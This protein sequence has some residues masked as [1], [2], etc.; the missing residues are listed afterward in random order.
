MNTLNYEQDYSGEKFEALQGDK[1]AAKEMNE[2]EEWKI[3]SWFRK[4][5]RKCREKKN[6]AVK[7]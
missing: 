6:R 3:V 4:I 1:Q 2:Y 7:H 5:I